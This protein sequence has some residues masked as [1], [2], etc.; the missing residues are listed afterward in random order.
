MPFP[1]DPIKA[2]ETR[3][4]ISEASKKKGEDPVYRKKM[5]DVHTGKIQ[6]LDDNH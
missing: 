6:P 3:I 2:E 1:K 4:M 5:S